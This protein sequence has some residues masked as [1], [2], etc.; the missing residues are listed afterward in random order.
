MWG[1]DCPLSH[2]EAARGTPI[3]VSRDSSFVEALFYALMIAVS[4][5][6]WNSSFVVKVFTMR[7]FSKS[8]KLK[9]F[10]SVV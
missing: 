10:S 2:I 7:P 9:Y 8:T 3:E 6:Y 5:G 1:K 4:Y